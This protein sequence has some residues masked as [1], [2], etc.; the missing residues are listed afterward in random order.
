MI[1]FELTFVKGVK[2]VS[3]FIFLHMDVQLSQ[4]HILKNYLCSF[5]LPLCLCQRSVDSFYVQFIFKFYWSSQHSTSQPFFVLPKPG[6]NL[7]SH[8][9]F[10]NY[11]SLVVF[12]WEISFLFLVIMVLTLWKVQACCIIE[13]P[14]IYAS[15]IVTSWFDFIWSFYKKIQHKWHLALLR[16]SL[17]E[18]AD[19]SLSRYW[20]CWLWL[21][22]KLLDFSTVKVHLSPF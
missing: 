12:V 7:G 1:H 22:G 9:T 15:L 6:F 3:T 13:R 18:T 16:T 8:V 5:V 11:L 19:V 2:S 20:W 10:S 14:S 17:Q 4:H 21:L